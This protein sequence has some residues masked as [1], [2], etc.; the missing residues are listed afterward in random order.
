MAKN[1]RRNSA[2]PH[3]YQTVTLAISTSL[4][5]I[6][7]GLMTLSV[8]TARNLSSYVKE[9][10]SVSL[11]LDQSLTDTQGKQL[12]K[13]LKSKRYISGLTFI[14]KEEALKQQQKEMGVNPADFVGVNPFSAEVELHLNADYANNDSLA[15]IKKELAK[16]KRISD[17]SCQEDLI[18]QVNITLNKINLGFLILA[19]VLTFVSFTLINNTVRLGV[20]ARRFAIRT[21]KLVGASWWFI[22]WPFLRNAL[23]VGLISSILACGAIGGAMY[24]LFTQEP[25]VRIVVTNEVLAITAAAIFLVGIFITFTCAFLSVNKF[26]SMKAGDLYKI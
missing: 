1:K 17:V 9:N 25:D 24:A 5:L 12:A 21:M 20:Y 22:R 4:V 6:L 26:L 15:W 8:L 19:A 13:Q 10:L 2:K 7:V 14:S 3:T 11:L 16:D 18:E 23:T